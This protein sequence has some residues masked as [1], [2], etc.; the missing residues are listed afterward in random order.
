MKYLISG[1]SFATI[2]LFSFSCIKAKEKVNEATEFSMDYSTEVAIP[3]TSV[4]LT[5]PAEFTSPDVQTLSGARFITEG[6]TQA[7]V[8][9]IVMT[10]FNVSNPAGNLDYLKSF[11][12]SIV[13]D[14]LSDILI[15]S[16]ANIPAG[17]TSV[18][19]D[20]SSVNIKNHIF[21]DKVRFKVSVTVNTVL[22]ADQRIKIDQSVKVKAKKI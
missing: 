2:V 14:N 19:A 4:N 18:A 3:S 12:I 11:S 5:G 22:A 8:D 1:I 20:L 6:T 10:K 9:E 16:K 13:A 21:K 7:L 17:S 15:A